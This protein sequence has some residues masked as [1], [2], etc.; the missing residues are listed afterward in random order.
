MSNSLF[1]GKRL[2]IFKF[3]G[4]YSREA[5]AI[6]IN[7]DL[8]S[9]GIIR[10]LERIVVWRGY[11][12]KFGMDNYGPKVIS[13]NVAGWVEEHQIELELIQLGKPTQNSYIERY[14]R[15]YRDEILNMYVFR[16]FSEFR[17]LNE[18][19]INERSEEWP[20]DSLSDLTPYEYMVTSKQSE[21]FRLLCPK[22]AIL[23][24]RSVITK[25]KCRSKYLSLIHI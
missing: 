18:C 11:P 17:E 6:Q 4:Y 7:I 20:H 8:P 10:V 5:L 3:I 14:N 1:F 19:W 23:T 12:T 16:A 25:G 24:C 13:T 9:E 15:T 2:R 22:P 21:N